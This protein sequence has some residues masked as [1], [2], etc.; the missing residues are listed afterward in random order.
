MEASLY[1]IE[2]FDCFNVYSRDDIKQFYHIDITDSTI[3]YRKLFDYFFSENYLLKYAENTTAVRFKPSKINYVTLY[4]QIKV[5]IDEKNQ[6]KTIS[7]LDTYL[8]QLMQSE[9]RLIDKDG[10]F[11][12]YLDKIGKIGEYIFSCILSEYFKFSCIIPK[13]HLETDY[14]MSVYGIDT[15]F[16]SIDEDLLL[17]GESKV[18]KNIINGVNLINRSLGEYKKQL[19]DEFTLVLSDRVLKNSLNIFTQKFGP[20]VEQ[21]TSIEKFIE[22]ANIKQI[23]I[24]IFIAHGEE[25]DQ[26]DVFD[27]LKKVHTTSFFN[28]QTNYY[29]ITL[30]IINKDD[31]T[32]EFTKFIK[33]KEDEYERNTN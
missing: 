10:K 19:Q 18:S 8:Q 26:D 2:Q 29:L 7:E 6:F 27:Q 17:F 14:N 28:L 23:G 12:I 9:G 25:L 24:P 5:F 16:Y 20:I 32:K 21:C 22:K 30:P 3:F 1:K 4:K 33:E 15:L 31:F 13:V 11:G